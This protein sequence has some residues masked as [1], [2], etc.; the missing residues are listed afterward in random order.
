LIRQPATTWIL[1]FARM[2]TLWYWI[3]IIIELA[4]EG[5]PQFDVR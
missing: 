5:V 1:A 4:A 2:T 3:A